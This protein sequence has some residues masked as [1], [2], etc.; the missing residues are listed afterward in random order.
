M[1]EM[2][3]VLEAY[4]E[5]MQR[6]MH[7]AMPAVVVSYDAA[8]KT[9]NVKPA[10]WQPVKVTGEHP[11]DEKGFTYVELPTIPDV[12]VAFPSGGGFY[13]VFPLQPGDA[14][15][16]VFSETPMGEYLLN[17]TVGAKPLDTRRHSLGYP[18]AIPGGARPD[19]KAIA[20]SSA[21]DLIVGKDG[22][23]SQI[24][25]SATD[26]QIGK[27]ATEYVALATKTFNE[28]KSLRD[29]VVT[30]THPVPSLGTS[31]APAVPPAAVGSVAATI[32]KAK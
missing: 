14:V 28:I 2:S 10:C 27:G 12:P 7:T 17:G 15:F 26:I 18:M 8:A 32:A 25:V 30:H 21:T 3:D 19:S 20:D 11:S 31:G 24:K 9:A 29:Y 23:D 4:R 22:T 6:N 13:V 16:L 5:A 1:T